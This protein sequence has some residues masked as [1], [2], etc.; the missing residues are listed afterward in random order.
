M[1]AAGIEGWVANF[2]ISTRSGHHYRADFAFPKRKLIIEYQSYLHEG[3][4]KFRADM[5]RVS[6]LQ[7]DEWFAMLVNVDDV[8]NPTELAQR[9]QHILDQRPYF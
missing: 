5:T 1:M 3:S 2:P 8:R 7:A 6:R 9:I 4:D